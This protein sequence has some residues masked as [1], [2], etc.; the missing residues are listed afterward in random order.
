MNFIFEGLRLELRTSPTY[1]WYVFGDFYYVDGG[2]AGTFNNPDADGNP[3]GTSLFGW[4]TSQDVLFQQ[5]L[6]TEFTG[7]MARES[8]SGVSE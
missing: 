4:F 2:Y 7:W 5:K 8:A 1:D 6:G 3:Q